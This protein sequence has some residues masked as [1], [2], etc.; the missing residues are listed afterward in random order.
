MNTQKNLFYLFVIILNVY[1]NS[2]KTEERVQNTSDF[3]LLR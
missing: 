2:E 3:V 1:A